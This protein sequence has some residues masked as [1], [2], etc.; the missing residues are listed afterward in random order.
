MAQGQGLQHHADGGQADGGGA[1]AIDPFTEQPGPGGHVEQRVEVVAERGVQR[2]AVVH[3]HDIGGPVGG[4]Q[5]RRQGQPAQHLGLTEDGD[6]LRPLTRDQH[7]QQG[8]EHAPD[9]AVAHDLPGVGALMR[10]LLKDQGDEAPQQVA[11][12]PRHQGGAGF[13]R[14]RRGGRGHGGPFGLRRAKAR[15][16]FQK[17]TKALKQPRTTCGA[18]GP[19]LKPSGCDSRWTG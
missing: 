19:L 11:T 13:G 15:R 5:H 4:D 10:H 3:R 12:H 17:E 8:P 7:Q 1:E 2:P 16:R 9:S 6:H 14:V 18:L